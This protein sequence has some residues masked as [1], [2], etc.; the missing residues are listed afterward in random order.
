[1]QG[2]GFETQTFPLVAGRK[3]GETNWIARA[4]IGLTRTFGGGRSTPSEAAVAQSG[5]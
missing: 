2:P 3:I 5:P 4:W 1:V